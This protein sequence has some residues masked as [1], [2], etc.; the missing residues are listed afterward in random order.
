MTL[1]T[2]FENG[3]LT[4]SRLYE[5]PQADV[6]AAWVEAGQTQEWWGCENTTHVKSEIEA[7]VGGKY[8][9]AMTIT[10]AGLY[11]ILGKFTAFEPPARLAYEM[12]GMSEG[13]TMQ[14]DVEFIPRGDGTEVKLTQSVL[15]SELSKVIQAGWSASFERLARYFDGERRAA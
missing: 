8:E 5:M 6:F 13:E 2:S 3:V 9:H 10:G 4:I 11:P 14:V 7:K 15:P 12:P 1:K